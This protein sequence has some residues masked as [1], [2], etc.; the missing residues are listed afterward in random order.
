M[1]FVFLLVVTSAV[2][3]ALYLLADP[4][5]A[6]D[7]SGH[8]YGNWIGAGFAIAFYAVVMGALLRSP[9]RRGWRHL[10]I[11][12]AYF[13]ALFTEMFGVPFTIYLL[14][15]VL[16]VKLGFGMLQGH[17]W[18]VLLDRLGLLPLEQGVGLVM[19]VS[20][21]MIL[22]GLGLMAAG[23]A[24]VRKADTR[25]VTTGLYRVV[26]HPQYLGF[27]LV[28]GAFLVQWPTL[29]T[30]VLFPVVLAVYMRLARWEEQELAG[31]FG[32]QW[33]E[34]RGRTPMLIPNLKLLRTHTHERSKSRPLSNHS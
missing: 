17:L 16:G 20:T 21:V 8:W 13:V 9:R 18:A 34:Y 6:G 7:T 23:W 19:A 26:R 10:G 33:S 25:L 32:S 2:T 4:E 14:G 29:P 5:L 3:V 31:R 22:W 24:Q 12:Q 27:L 15:S 30:V 11:G 1:G 28:A